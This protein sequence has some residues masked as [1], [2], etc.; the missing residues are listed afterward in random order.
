MKF[1]VRIFFDP[2]RLASAAAKM[3][4]DAAGEAIVSKGSFTAALSG[5]STPRKLFRTLGTTYCDTV[6]WDSVQLFW[7]DERS[8]PPD[9]EQSNY[10]L[11]CEELI[12]KAA[13][14]ARNI[15]RIR[16]ELNP[17]KAAAEYEREMARY[18]GSVT[19]PAFDLIL[20]GVG[21]DGHTASLF[22]GSEALLVTDHFAVP[23]YSESSGNWRVTLTLPVLNNAERILFLV[24]GTSKSGIISEIFTERIGNHYPAELM[25]P[26]RGSVIWLLDR[27]AASALKAA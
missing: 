19:V 20:L 1:D 13:I 14:P 2:D 24:S 25:E 8:V 22:P 3:F 9:H 26:S 17:A 23:S 7:T 15:H 18:F 5:G 16:G 4:A 6:K 27:E 11:A 21:Q 10:R 12:S